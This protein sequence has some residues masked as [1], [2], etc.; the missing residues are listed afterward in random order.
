MQLSEQQILFF[1]TFGF[2]VFRQHLSAEE[3]ERLNPEF[4]AAIDALVPPSGKS[5][6]RVG[7]LFLDADTP[8]LSAL[9]D[10]P[11]FADIAE[12][13]LEQ[14]A[15][16]IGIAGNYYVGDTRWHSDSR[17]LDYAGVKFA[18]YLEPLDA[19]NGALRLI[20]GSHQNPMW[21]KSNMHRDTE[22]VFGIAPQDM[23]DYAFESRPGDV[24]AFKLPIWHASFGGGVRRRMIEVV[25]YADPDTP[26]AV[27][28]FCAQMANNHQSS[29]KQGRQFYTKYWRSVDHPRHRS[30]IQRMDELGVLDTPGVPPL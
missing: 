5:T 12:Q 3:L 26:E 9:G 18:I 16:C 28:T 22:R 25:Y 29:T 17:S 1:N 30:W 11:R 13:V 24:L 14:A 15:I 27:E 20:P 6:E 7:R 8:L 10:D 21:G 2:L 4:N 19:T 23:P